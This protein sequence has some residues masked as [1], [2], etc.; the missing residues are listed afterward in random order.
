MAREEGWLAE[1]MLI[2]GTRNLPEGQRAL[3][4]GRAVPRA[5]GKT[6]LAMLVPPEAT[7]ERGWAAETVGRRH[8]LAAECGDADRL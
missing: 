4:R 6:N 7:R 2:V 8:R 1:H 5:C 3:R